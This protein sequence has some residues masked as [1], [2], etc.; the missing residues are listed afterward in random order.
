MTRPNGLGLVVVLNEAAKEMSGVAFQ[1]RI[2]ALDAEV[3]NAKNRSTALAGFREV[4]MQMRQ[5]SDELS[6]Q[7][8][9]L[10][11]LCAEAV[12][13]ESKRRVL[14]RKARLIRLA[15][16]RSPRQLAGCVDAL[17]GRERGAGARRRGILLRTLVA[18]EDL[19]QLGMMAVVLSRAAKIEAASADVEERAV[20]A[21]VAQEFAAHSEAVLRLGKSLFPVVSQAKQEL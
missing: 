7:L 6:Q 19:S 5:W 17:E 18:L 4:S 2:C 20:L 21:Q 9:R 13:D 8:E 12:V 10:R 16:E 15:A 3:R 11:D 14:Q 1:V